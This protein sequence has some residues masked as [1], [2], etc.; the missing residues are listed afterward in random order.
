VWRLYLAS[1]HRKGGKDVE[2]HSC[3]PNVGHRLKKNGLKEEDGKE[4]R[5]G[6]TGATNT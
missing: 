2:G 4:V 3:D 5:G 1:C 6:L